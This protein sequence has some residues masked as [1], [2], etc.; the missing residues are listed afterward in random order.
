MSEFSTRVRCY[1]NKIIF[2][3]P[4]SRIIRKSKRNLRIIKID[5]DEDEQAKQR[6][7]SRSRSASPQLRFIN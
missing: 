4:E 3:N 6:D 7:H 5:E 2:S 1:R